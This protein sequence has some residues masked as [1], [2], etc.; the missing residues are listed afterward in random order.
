VVIDAESVAGL[1]ANAERDWRA[2][3]QWFR[4]AY[5]RGGLVVCHDHI[6]VPTLEGSM[7]AEPTDYLIRGIKGELYPCK[8]DVFAA[9]YEPVLSGLGEIT[10]DY[11]DRIAGH[12]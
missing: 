1:I 2:L 7:R 4:D 3:P 8:P 11:R 5:E 12:R 10:D 9:S 6:D